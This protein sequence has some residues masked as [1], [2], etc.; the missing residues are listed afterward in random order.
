MK[1]SAKQKLIIKEMRGGMKVHIVGNFDV[2]LFTDKRG[3]TI[4]WATASSLEDKGLLERHPRY[5]SLTE[6]GKQVGI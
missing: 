2:T 1:L 5:Y 6:K 3:V 4:S